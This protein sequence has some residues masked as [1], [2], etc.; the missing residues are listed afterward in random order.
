[1]LSPLCGYG[2]PAAMLHSVQPLS[3]RVTILSRDRTRCDGRPFP[4]LEPL[5]QSV[6]LWG[7][8]IHA[9]PCPLS[10]RPHR[11]SYRGRGGG[12]V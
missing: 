5:A 4:A 12:H 1:M 10:L 6:F 11:V 7:Y 8:G 2:R 9:H 3:E